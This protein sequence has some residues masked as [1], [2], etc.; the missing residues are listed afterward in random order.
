[1]AMLRVATRRSDGRANLHQG[2]LG[3]GVELSTG[4]VR[5]ACLGNR[6]TATHPDTGEALLGRVVPG[7][8][9]ALPLAVRAASLTG[10]GYV[11]VDLMIDARK[12]PLLVEMNA[13]P[14]LAIQI[15]NG[16]GLRPRLR[17]IDL[18]LEGRP[19]EDPVERIAFARERFV[20]LQ[21]PPG[22]RL[23]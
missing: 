21:G 14:G 20:R 18:R 1:M 9:V 19:D 23:G 3:L 6:F 4:V 17:E 22:V 10:L 12:G 5:H 2:A 15:A 13:R 16:C 7:W 8:E 11:G